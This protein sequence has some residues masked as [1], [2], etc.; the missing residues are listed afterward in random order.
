MLHKVDTKRSYRQGSSNVS[1]PEAQPNPS[2]F[3][4]LAA[5]NLSAHAAQQVGM[6]AAPIVAVTVLGSGIG[7][8]AWI[9]LGQMLPFLLFSIPAGVLADRLPVKV[10][11]I[12]GEALR[13]V[14]LLCVPF[15]A[16]AGL[17]NVPV[18]ALLGLAGSMGSLAYSVAIPSL[19]RSMVQR[20][21]LPAANGRLELVRSIAFI[22][23]PAL[24]GM[25]IAST[26]IDAAFGLAALLSLLAIYLLRGIAEPERGQTEARHFF[27]ELSEGAGFAFKH[28]LLGSAFRLSVL[29]NTAFFI[30]Q[31]VFIP[32]AAGRLGMSAAD[33]GITLS[34]YGIGMVL[35]GLF[36]PTFVRRL[37]MGQMLVAGCVTGLL[38][39]MAMLVTLWHPARPF[40]MLCFFLLG[41]GPVLWTVSFTTLRQIVTPAAMLGRATS[42]NSLATYGAR[43][44]GAAA[45]GVI[46]SAFG[47]TACLVSVT[48]LFAVQAVMLLLSPLPYLKAE[49]LRSQ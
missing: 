15:I 45:A 8:T 36:I 41:G 46:G 5:S 29:Y 32:Y 21:A 44:L 47:M 37:S 22:G 3:Q 33:I 20:D 24:A 48:A 12:S 40:A 39:S 27:V 34:F 14:S 25:L 2:S 38:A 19:T 30:L 6:A 7:Q 42:V 17:F 35:C 49:E 26:G 10:L 43:P 1:T 16:L 31:T 9:Q 18:L 4:R 23:G 11:M 28:P 13:A